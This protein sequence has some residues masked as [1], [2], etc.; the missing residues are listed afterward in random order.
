MAITSIEIYTAMLHNIHKY[1]NLLDIVHKENSLFHITS[2]SHTKSVL[3]QTPEKDIDLCFV[4]FFTSV[5]IRGRLYYNTLGL[6]RNINDIL[7]FDKKGSLEKLNI[8]MEEY[9]KNH[10]F[11]NTRMSIQ[12]NKTDESN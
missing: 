6:T 1:T 4:V 7:K 2:C 11:I 12:R 5:Q 9:L 8:K 10:I 3:L